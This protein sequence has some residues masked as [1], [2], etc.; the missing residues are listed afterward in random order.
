MG[1]FLVESDKKNIPIG[2]MEDG[3]LSDPFTQYYG[4]LLHQG[5]MLQDYIRTGTYQ[6]AFMEN[7][8][9]F[10]GKV[11]LDCGTGTGILAMFAVQA[12]AKK[13][14]AIEASG[15]ANVAR[16]LVEA[17]GLSD[18]IEVIQ[19][20]IQKVEIPEKVDIIVS[21]PIGFLLVH[22]RMLEVYTIARERFLKEDGLM[23]PSTGSIIFAPMTDAALHTEQVTKADFWSTTDFYGVDLSSAVAVAKKEYFSQPVVGCFPPSILISAQRAV[24]TVDFGA[25]TCEELQNF[26]I[27]FNFRID[28]TELMHGFGCWFDISFDGTTSS[29]ILSTHPDCPATH[30][31]QCRL[32]FPDPL[33]V[34]KGQN[35]YGSMSFKANDKFSFFVT[36]TATIDGTDITTTNVINLHDQM[37]HYLN[38]SS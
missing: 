9:D 35:V 25:T 34:N 37:Y 33:A 23:F 31:Y 24:H 1:D 19:G 6:R 32:L 5:N 15:A 4:Q 36:I 26:E 22:E 7:A 21:E 2:K 38:G 27:D 14:Y 29:V 20:R 17:N 8:S 30:W 3:S 18:K 11:V 10:E 13:V 28:K 16:A 12:G